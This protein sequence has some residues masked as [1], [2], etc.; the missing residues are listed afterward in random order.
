[1][2]PLKR[3]IVTNKQSHEKGVADKANCQALDVK[4]L[5]RVD[6]ND[7]VVWVFGEQFDAILLSTQSF[8]GDFIA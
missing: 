1:M 8:D 5:A 2:E 7:G 6:Q 3:E 4:G